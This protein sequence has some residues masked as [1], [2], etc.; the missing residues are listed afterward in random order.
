MFNRIHTSGPLPQHQHVMPPRCG[1][2]WLVPSRYPTPML[3]IHMGLWICGA[4]RP[5]WI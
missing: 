4:S 1:S 3:R 2:L 5:F